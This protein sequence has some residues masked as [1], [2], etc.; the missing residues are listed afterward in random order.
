[1]SFLPHNQLP[2][3]IEEFDRI[4][5][6]EEFFP[7]R[8]PTLRHSLARVLPYLPSLRHLLVPSAYA[9]T[10]L[11]AESCLG[12][13]GVEIAI[14]RA[15]LRRRMLRSLCTQYYNALTDYP[16]LVEAIYG[17]SAPLEVLRAA[18][19]L[20][21]TGYAGWILQTDEEYLYLFERACDTV[22]GPLAPYVEY[23]MPQDDS[24]YEQFR[25]LVR[26][27][28][29]FLRFPDCSFIG[30]MLCE[31]YT[32][33]QFLFVGGQSILVRDIRGYEIE[34]WGPEVDVFDGA[35]QTSEVFHG[36]FDGF[37]DLETIDLILDEK[38]EDD[39][40]HDG[41]HDDEAIEEDSSAS[42][43]DE[44]RRGFYTES[45]WEDYAELDWL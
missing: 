10:L 5:P 44:E 7:Q 22:L 11:D 34:P 4:S 14:S 2:I 36:D 20:R 24:Q 39:N 29:G 43:A 17:Q 30:N 23:F 6:C 26:L 40:S 38:R 28:R 15:Q 27:A 8:H 13:S 18:V 3:D 19:H 12:P 45:E 21:N 32:N 42:E 1:M 35:S 31:V 25:E 41:P 37:D 9:E 33:C 16:T